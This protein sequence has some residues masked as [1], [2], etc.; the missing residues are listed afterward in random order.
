MK[1]DYISTDTQTIN[2]PLTFTMM[3]I[4]FLL[5]LLGCDK[6]EIEDIEDIEVSAVKDKKELI[7]VYPKFSPQTRGESNG[8][9]EAWEYIQLNNGLKVNTPWNPIST[10]S[11]T[12]HDILEDIKYAD[13]WE[14]IFHLLDDSPNNDYS[15]NSPYLI[16]HNR[17]TGILKVFCYLSES[18]F[19]PNNHGIWQL[20]TD[21]NTS[22]FAFQNDPITK[23]SEKRK[24]TYYVSNITNSSTQ[25]FSVGWNCFQIELAYDPSQ[26][27]W[28]EISTLAS[29][30]VEL[31]LTG[32]L[33][34]STEGLITT[35]SGKNNYGSGIANIA[36]KEAGTWIQNKIKDKTILGIPSSIISEG[37]KALVSG[38][39]GSIINAL[40][41][42]FKSD[43]SS[44]SFQLTTN[45]T[46]NI[47]G[48]ATFEST[49]GIPSIQ[50]S[51]DPSIIGHLGVWGLQNEPTL[52][53]SPYASLKS[54]QEYSN[55]FSREY[56]TNIVNS[57]A[58]AT[59]VFNP[60]L[61]QYI[62]TSS[63]STSYY[64]SSNYTR[65]NIWGTTGVVGR[66]QKNT[67]KVYDNLFKP[68]FNIL[69]D[70][71]FIGDE[72]E[73][74]PINQFDPPYEVFIPNVPNGPKGAISNF[75]YHS[76]YIA[77]I[78][79]KITLPNGD[80]A[81]SY[82]HC[83]PKIDWNYNDFNNGLYWS[84]YP[85]EPITRINSYNFN[86]RSERI[87]ENY[88]N[89]IRIPINID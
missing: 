78:G 7:G 15:R 44:K 27:G 3:I 83:I 55:G 82:H 69:A 70:V 4:C 32:N 19:H 26:S 76:R 13:G 28:L 23:I 81:Y 18:S 51:L 24:D 1:K 60:E 71:T 17:Y 61:T 56:V 31:S 62:S 66:D 53:F 79:V 39:V 52:L 58:N 10:S 21:S 49:T 59:V 40:T 34:T 43:N 80:E 46:F 72:N 87:L 77:S 38:G 67:S 6:Y 73:R 8:Y 85:C 45:G 41:G 86:D 42:L 22:L 25:G 5:V 33:K 74:I 57:N 50:I 63:A 2:A 48:T 47:K 20:D 65:R 64:Q 68:N 37:V 14:L 89:K 11:T 75:I 29:N 35:S 9:W 16:F 88:N 12:P 84:I 54:P 30:T 36:G